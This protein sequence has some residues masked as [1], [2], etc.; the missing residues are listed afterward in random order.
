MRHVSTQFW[1]ALVI[2]GLLAVCSSSAPSLWSTKVVQ[3][4][5]VSG[6]WSDKVAA[7]VA[8]PRVAGHGWEVALNTAGPARSV[9]QLEA[10]DL[11]VQ[12]SA[13]RI[14]LVELARE[15]G[16]TVGEPVHIELSGGS[17][18]KEGATLVRRL[19]AP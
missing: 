13:A 19:D 11:S 3:S 4:S 5:G 6:A 2:V 1:S 10:P 16:G 8:A 17:L 7:D 15:S 12:A 9:L 14:T 18:P